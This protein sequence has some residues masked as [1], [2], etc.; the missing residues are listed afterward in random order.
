MH[1]AGEIQTDD[2]LVASLKTGHEVF[3]PRFTRGVSEMEMLRLKNEEALRGLKPSLWD[4]RQFGEEHVVE[5]YFETGTV[6]YTVFK[7]KFSLLYS[8]LGPLDLVL[9][10]GVAFTTKG[11]RLG[12]GKGF[13]DRFLHDHKRR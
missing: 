11:E 4:I 1:T 8:F 6:F 12:H 7:Q 10:P 9:L 5:A 2:I 13:Y 3:I